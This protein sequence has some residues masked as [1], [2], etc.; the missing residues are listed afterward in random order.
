M[1]RALLLLAALS[2]AAGCGASRQL[3]SDGGPSADGNHRDLHFDSWPDNG[4]ECGC[5]DTGMDADSITTGDPQ[6]L[7]GMVVVWRG[8][9]TDPAANAPVEVR[10]AGSPQF[11]SKATYTDSQGNFSVKVPAGA[12]VALKASGLNMIAALR[13]VDLSK[14]NGPVTLYLAELASSQAV[15]KQLGTTLDERLGQVSVQ[16]AGDSFLRYTATLSAGGTAFVYDANNQPQLGNTTY[17]GKREVAFGNVP[18]GTTTVKVTAPEIAPCVPTMG[19]GY[20]Y[21]I[22]VN[23]TTMIDVICPWRGG[24]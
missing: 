24:V 15:A 2:L 5:S 12:K 21:P 1:R 10:S 7:S 4:L 8:G 20:N 17:T 6:T 22:E 19:S 14:Q 11:A 13:F 16:I 23:T 18:L 3:A 9:Q